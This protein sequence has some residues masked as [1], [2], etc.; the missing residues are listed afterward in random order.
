MKSLIATVLVLLFAAMSFA[1]P[2]PPKDKDK[3]PAG[4]LLT[5]KVIDRGDTPLSGAVVYL[6][7]SRTHSLKT[8]I[9]GPDGAYHF[10]SLSLNDDYEV[11]AQFNG[12]KSDVKT[13]SQFDTRSISNINLRIDAH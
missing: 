7:D 12:K 10:P 13:V 11:Y 6:A 3:T 1:V 4:R 9:T 5:G 8:Y 2:F